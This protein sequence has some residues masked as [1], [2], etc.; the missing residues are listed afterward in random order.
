MEY[1]IKDN[2]YSTVKE[3]LKNEFKFSKR[4][5][6]KLKQEKRIYVND[7]PQ[8]VNFIVKINDIVRVDLN[9][10]EVSDN[11]VPFKMD[12]NIIYEDDYLIV[13]NKP[14]KIE[15]HPTAFNN[16]KTLSNGLKFYFDT[17][18]LKRKIRPVNRLDKDTSGIIIFAKNQYVQEE[19][20]KQMRNNLFVKEYIA[21]VEGN[22]ENTRGKI[23]ANIARKEDSILERCIDNKNG[24]YAETYYEVIGKCKSCNATII[25]LKLKTR[26]DTSNKSSY[27]TY[28]S[29]FNRRLLVW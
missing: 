6:L 8:F 7:L 25:K 29:S 11:I 17:I 4:L 13:L 15:T 18:N 5:I 14:P 9:F 16:T 19:L 27:E 1:K 21:I 10:N 28:R 26:K 20:I 24:V 3:V 23:I 2:K 12:I 22:M